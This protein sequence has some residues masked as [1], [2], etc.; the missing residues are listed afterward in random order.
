VVKLWSQGEAFGVEQGMFGLA[1]SHPNCQAQFSKSS[2]GS[3]TIAGSGELIVF[4]YPSGV[5]V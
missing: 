4:E 5:W 1:S 2:V 3:N